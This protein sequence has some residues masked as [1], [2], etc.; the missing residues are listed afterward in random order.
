MDMAIITREVCD[1]GA[2]MESLTKLAAPY[3]NMY[4]PRAGMGN[5][6]SWRPDWFHTFAPHHTLD[7]NN[8]DLQFIMQLVSSAMFS[9][10]GEK[11]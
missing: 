11:E 5:S 6:S 2:A 4:G 10:H 3:M 1:V 7:F 9:R 8:H